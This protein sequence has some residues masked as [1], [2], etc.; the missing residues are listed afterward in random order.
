[1]GDFAADR[2]PV[3]P[4]NYRV[5]DPIGPIA[6]A[7][8]HGITPE[9]LG[10][11]DLAGVAAVGSI[12]TENLGIEHLVEN[13]IANPHIRHLVVFGHD[14]PGHLAGDALVCLSAQGTEP[15][16]RIPGARGA[17]P[18]LKNLKPVEVEH[19]RS[20]VGVVDLIGSTDPSVLA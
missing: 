20:Q 7:L 1:M 5:L 4:G 16:G 2:W 11:L 10:G 19:F 6:L 3:L 9:D 13:I 12:A 18:V 15:G 17:R 8:L 14:T